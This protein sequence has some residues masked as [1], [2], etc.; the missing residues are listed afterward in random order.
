MLRLLA[1]PILVA[2]AASSASAQAGQPPVAPAS[3]SDW[4]VECR[5]GHDGFALNCEAVRSAGDYALR[6]VTAD[7]QLFVLIAHDRCEPDYRSFDR[8]DAIGLAAAE[9]RAAVERAFE[10]IALEISRICPA[11]APPAISLRAMPDLAILSPDT[12]H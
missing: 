3:R 2:A 4:A 6:L 7:D 11:L 10:E 5:T 9:R 1:L 8:T 12:D